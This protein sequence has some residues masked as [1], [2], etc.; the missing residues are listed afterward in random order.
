MR[1]MSGI[2]LACG[3]LLFVGQAGAKDLVTIQELL[4]KQKLK[5][6]TWVEPKGEIVVSQRVNLKI[7]ISSEKWFTGGTRI[8]RLE[9]RDAIVLQQQGFATNYTLRVGADTWSA[10]EWTITIFPQQ[11]GTFEIPEI[12]ITL[13]VAGPGNKSVTGTATTKPIRFQAVVPAG[14]K[15][16]VGWVATT[17]F[18][19]DE[20]F[21][22]A[23][24]NLKPGDVVRRTVRFS[25][26]DIPAMMLPK[27][28]SEN[29]DGLAVYRKSPQVRDNTN[30]GAIIGKR[31]ETLSYMVERPGEY[32]LPKQTFYWWNLAT[33]NVETVTLPERIV[34]ATVASLQKESTDAEEADLSIFPSI[35]WR[36]YLLWITYA[37]LIGLM[38]W[39]L[40]R[41]IRRINL[42]RVK[43]DV[44]PPSEAKLRS[45]FRKECR[46]DSPE[47]ALAALYRWLDLNANASYQGSIRIFLETISA[48]NERD[49]FNQLMKRLYGK[50]VGGSSSVREV[51]ERLL[52]LAEG[53]RHR[54]KEDKRNPTL[55]LN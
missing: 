12:Q 35:D 54:W 26:E 21:D 44:K 40:F 3:A 39:G 22:K 11:E 24:E 46:S 53:R 28:A 23:L 6:R 49:Q 55:H 4:T 16:R 27:L 36:T 48:E 31:T 51:G 32:V 14:I 15:G 42:S 47:K 10:Q 37:I 43:A 45:A 25:A 50:S 7:E 2:F 13:S 5:I 20:S 9:I 30:R 29:F 18:E 8:G 17:R 1:W 19:V 38:I 33:G 52:A 41:L 34:T